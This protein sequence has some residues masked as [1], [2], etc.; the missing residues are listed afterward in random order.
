MQQSE[1]GADEA[2]AEMQ[3]QNIEVQVRGPRNVQNGLEGRANLSEP[4]NFESFNSR[5]NMNRLYT[6]IKHEKCE[7][8]NVESRKTRVG[9]CEHK[10]DSYKQL[11]AR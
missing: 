11:R 9:N 4:W 8:G 3:A 5:E 6:A 2:N 10:I 7:N 1:E